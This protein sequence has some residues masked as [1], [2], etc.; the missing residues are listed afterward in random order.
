M[1]PTFGQK[2]RLAN[3]QILS[4]SKWLSNSFHPKVRIGIYGS[5]NIFSSKK[6]KGTQLQADSPIIKSRQQASTCTH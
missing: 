2:P 3:E 5:I 1:L 4:T 6:N